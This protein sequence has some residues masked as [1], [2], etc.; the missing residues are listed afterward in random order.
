MRSGDAEK[1][2][3][4]SSK[5]SHSNAP[6]AETT[7]GDPD[8]NRPIEEVVQFVLYADRLKSIVRRSQIVDGSRRENVAEHSWH[9]ALFALLL[10]DRV[11]LHFERVIEMLLIHDLVEIDV[12]AGEED[13][14]P[15][16]YDPEDLLAAERVAAVFVFGRLGPPLGPRLL[17]IWEEFAAGTS[18]E[19]RFAR[20]LDCAHPVLLNTRHGGDVWREHRTERS[21]VVQRI[22]ELRNFAPDLYRLLVE[23]VDAVME[24]G[25]MTTSELSELDP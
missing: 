7:Y 9:V 13:R 15:Y 20:S 11:D 16:D 8:T 1:D 22:S 14:Y 18:P 4:L 17:R 10:S 19:A 23:A 24:S 12:N 5:S 3:R 2:T 25:K 6:A 21:Q